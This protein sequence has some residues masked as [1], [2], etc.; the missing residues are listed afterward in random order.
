MNRIGGGGEKK[1]RKKE[2][3]N[4]FFFSEIGNFNIGPVN[5]L[6]KKGLI[7]SD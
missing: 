2:N 5:K 4:F 1:E 6:I 3:S 7:Y